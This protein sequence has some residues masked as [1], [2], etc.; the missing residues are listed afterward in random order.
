MKY[1]EFCESK[2]GLIA[3]RLLD[4][5]SIE[6]Q[7]KRKRFCQEFVGEIASYLLMLLREKKQSQQKDDTNSGL[8]F[9]HPSPRR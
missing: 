9:G 5:L 2:I 3:H 4:M 7:D 1:Q 8:A 6:H